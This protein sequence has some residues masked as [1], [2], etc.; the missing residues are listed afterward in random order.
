MSQSVKICLYNFFKFCIIKFKEV[1]MRKVVLTMKENEKYV[2][3][4]NVV[5]K[6]GNNQELLLI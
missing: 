2:T 3:I 1:T 5:E 6:N 4:K